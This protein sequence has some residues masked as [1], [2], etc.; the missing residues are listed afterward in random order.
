[1]KELKKVE[2]QPLKH[3]PLVFESHAW[4]FPDPGLVACF[5]VK[6]EK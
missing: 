3:M 2:I 6:I 4:N 5:Q 1:M